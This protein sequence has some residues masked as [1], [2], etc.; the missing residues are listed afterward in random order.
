MAILSDAGGNGGGQLP[1]ARPCPPL[2]GT[3]EPDVNAGPTALARSYRRAN[4]IVL[5]VLGV[6]VLLLCLAR[7]NPDRPEGV[8]LGGLR[9][10]GLCVY[11][12]VTGKPCLG[13]GITRGLA[14][15]AH[16]HVRAATRM[17]P[18]AVWLCAWLVAQMVA[19]SW[20]VLRPARREIRPTLDV[21]VSV[22][23]LMAAVY[24]PILHSV[25]AAW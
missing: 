13:C 1:D 8:A 15:L 24:V 11:R 4:V 22:T 17:H 16:G 9:L 6:P 3:A 10:P 7:V 23:T 5:C 25:L 18:S 14:L 2:S 21:T 20:M 19:R 12:L